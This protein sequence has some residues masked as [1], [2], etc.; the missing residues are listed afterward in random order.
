MMGARAAPA[1]YWRRTS[2]ALARRVAPATPI[3]VFGNFIVLN[4]ECW[5]IAAEFGVNACT[6]PRFTEKKF[7]YVK[8]LEEVASR[9]RATFLSMRQA[10]CADGQCL[11]RVGDVPFTW[12]KFHF[13]YEFSAE[14]GRR[15]GDEVRLS[16][17]PN[18]PP[19]T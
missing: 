7:L 3:F 11:L 16:R 8:E 6:E 9:N 2:S 13:S 5:E 14:L 1:S 4:R 10:F 15:I 18:G 19:S 12:D 17:N